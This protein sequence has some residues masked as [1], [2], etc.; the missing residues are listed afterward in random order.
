[1]N[2]VRNLAAFLL[3]CI[4]ALSCRKESFTSNPSY[5]LQASVDTLHFDTVF[6]STGSI[7]QLVKLINPNNKSIRVE[8]VK[9]AGGNAS[10][11]KINVDG[12]PGPEVTDLEILADDSLY[13]FVTVSIDPGSSDLAFLEQDSIRIDYNGNIKYVQLDAYGQ[14][15]HFFRNK[16]VSGTET[17]TNDRPYVILGRLTVDTNA[18]LQIQ[19]GCRIYV[20]AD[21]P[22]I[23]N[24]SL[25]VTGEKWDSTRVIFSGDRLDL[26]Y[27]NYPASYPGIYF[28]DV[29][30]NN[31]LRY[32]IVKNAYQGIVVSD[33][34]PGT[35]LTLEETIIDNA[36]DAG[37][38][39]I[40]TS[41][42][43]R[44][45]LISNC[46][47]NLMLVKGGTYNFNHVTVSALSN[48]YVQH[49]DPALVLTNYLVQ[50]NVAITSNLNANFRNCIFWGEANGL[51]EDEVSVL[52]QGTAPFNV[53]F[54]GVLW[55]VKNNPS[56]V[57]ATS[58]LNNLD[59][60]FDSINISERVFSFRLQPSSPA[61]NKGVNAG[62]TLDLDGAPRPV[63]LPDLGAYE[64]Q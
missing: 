54:D 46:G 5:R 13:V 11:F 27:R 38:I 43:A 58:V 26:P 23:I 17:W 59:P 22:V 6:T 61:I 64:K 24:G 21:A 30:R 41:I 31:L 52:K 51:V 18:T 50:N 55:R 44:N 47:K 4:C 9:L 29:S 20:H 19:K 2:P 8:S 42:A 62:V 25:Q 45:L 57:T 32:A 34:A 16:K 63:G 48:G 33:P 49:K 40:N 53:S 15:A 39:G 12:R 56:S 28:T 14:N 35:K 60:L 3:I 10:P 7:T 1:M 36:Y 37:L